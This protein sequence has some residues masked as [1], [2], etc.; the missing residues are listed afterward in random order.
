MTLTAARYLGV[1]PWELEQQHPIW[2]FW[3]LEAQAAEPPQLVHA[4]LIQ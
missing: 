1:K 4:K 2:K 3:A